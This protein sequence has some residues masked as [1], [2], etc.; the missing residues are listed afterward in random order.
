MT[1][2]VDVR[3]TIVGVLRRPNERHL[4]AVLFSNRCDLI[5]VG[6]HDD[7]CDSSGIKGLKNGPGNQRLAGDLDDV[8]S[9]NALR[10]TS[11]G[12]ERKDLTRRMPAGRKGQ[13][14]TPVQ[15]AGTHDN[16]SHQCAATN[17]FR[18]TRR[19]FSLTGNSLS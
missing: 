13:L 6:T 9:R 12:Y 7:P 3:C 19:S 16:R 17:G 15:L 4:S 10:P 5:I 8:L 14:R 11:G 1:K 2:D 18:P